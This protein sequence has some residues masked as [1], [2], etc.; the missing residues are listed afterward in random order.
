MAEAEDGLTRLERKARL[1]REILLLF[2][3]CELSDSLC[4]SDSVYREHEPALDREDYDGVMMAIGGAQSELEVAIRRLRQNHD[5]R[6]ADAMLR[7]LHEVTKHLSD[8][9]K[10][11]VEHY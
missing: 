11:K 10:M 9:A 5:V 6:G 3:L 8:I 1:Q 7:A 2:L 4:K